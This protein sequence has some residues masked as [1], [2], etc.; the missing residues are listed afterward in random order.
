MFA[1]SS[2]YEGANALWRGWFWFLGY[3]GASNRGAA[4][5]ALFLS[6]FALLQAVF[7]IALGIAILRL[8]PTWYKIA[9]ITCVVLFALSLFGLVFWWNHPDTVSL[10]AF[11]FWTIQLLL[12]MWFYRVLQ[13]SEIRGLFGIRSERIEEV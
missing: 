4:L 5:L 9:A 1:T 3:Q 12:S 7:F 11:F 2:F 10:P 8:W 6:F 13:R